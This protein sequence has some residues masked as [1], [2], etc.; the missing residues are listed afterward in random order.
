MEFYEIFIIVAA[1]VF[2]IAV[3]AGSVV[4]GHRKKDGCGGGCAG[5]RGCSACRET[6]PSARSKEK[7]D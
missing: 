7:K 5:C 4:R 6:L 2:V 3:I 1:S